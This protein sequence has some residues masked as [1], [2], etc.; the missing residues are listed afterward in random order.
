MRT[1]NSH[2][3]GAAVTVPF[4]VQEKE[5]QVTNP[6][7]IMELAAVFRNLQQPQFR[8]D[9]FQILAAAGQVPMLA[10][11]SGRDYKA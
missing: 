8:S 11:G 7:P 5:K 4:R 6:K 2:G 9:T 1:C 3:M 10:S